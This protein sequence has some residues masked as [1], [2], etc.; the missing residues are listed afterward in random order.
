VQV[1]LATQDSSEDVRST[2]TQALEERDGQD[3]AGLMGGP[4]LASEVAAYF[5]DL[6]AA[7]AAV[8]E[9]LAQNTACPQAALNRLAS[10][11]E[12]GVLDR[13]LRNETLLIAHP[14]S[15]SILETNQ[16]LSPGQRNRLAEIRVHF[17]EQPLAEDESAAP[18][19]PP[20]VTRQVVEAMVAA[21]QYDRESR[22]GE[23]EE[24]QY[25]DHAAA[26]KH[27]MFRIMD[28]STAEK[29]KLA[30]LGT[31][32]ERNILI[33]DSNR[34]VATSVLKSPRVNEK[35][36]ETYANM[37]SISEELITMIANKRDWIRSY[38][39]M[40][41]VIRHPKTPPRLTVNFLPRVQD[42]DLKLLSRDRNLPEMTRQAVRRAFLARSQRKSGR[43]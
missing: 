29:V 23:E 7:S 30:F 6:A 15:L 26:E 36:V 10:R 21:E 35:D 2:A 37:R 31:P 8:L 27:A 13:L 18:A 34:V 17:V 42:R 39:V 32:E 3:V 9:A 12:P 43:H 5:A 11:D 38:Q 1:F 16:A 22:S 19:L 20:E 4:D 40:L 28:M 25:M 41:G 33:R 24:P 14:D